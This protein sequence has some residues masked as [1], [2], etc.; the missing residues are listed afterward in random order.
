MITTHLVGRADTCLGIDSQQ[1]RWG[2]DDEFA[3]NAPPAPVEQTI[4]EDKLA[5]VEHPP[6]GLFHSTPRNAKRNSYQRLSRLSDEA[7]LSI[8]SFSPVPDRKG[9]DSNRSSTTIKAIQV[10][11]TSALNDVDFEKALRKFASER[12]SF[13]ADLTLSAGAVMPSR[14]KTRPKTQRIINEENAGLK[15]GV[16]SIRRRMSFRDMGSMKRQSTVGRQGECLSELADVVTGVGSR[17]ELE[18]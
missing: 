17:A 5:E 11:G 4:E 15:S 9:T 8:T 13:L 3:N 14:P 1:L 12:D 2:K 16:G 10:N 7:R 18:T 6:S